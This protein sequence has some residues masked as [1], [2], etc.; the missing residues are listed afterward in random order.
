MSD[1]M[2]K[3]AVE[4]IDYVRRGGSSL[5]LRLFKPAGPGPH[6]IVVDIHG[7]AWNRGDLTEGRVRDEVLAAAGF[8]VAAVDFRQ[9]GDGYPTSLV[10]INYAIRWL[11]AHAAE[12]GGDANSV[13]LTGQSS[14]GHL[15][16]LSAMRPFDRRYAAE[17]LAGGDV[18][19]SVKC[20]AALWPVINPLSRY[21]HALRLRA[22][23]SPPAWVA[24]IPEQHD[25]YWGSE[26][27]MEE[28]NPMLILERGETVE[29]P[30]TLWVQGR[31]DEIHDYREPGQDLNEPQRFERNYR[32]A[33]GE[34]DILYVEQA[35][36]S[37]VA[38]FEAI[39]PFMR[40]HLASAAP[41]R[42][43][44]ARRASGM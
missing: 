14:G 31:P 19:A 15:A 34:L 25:I 27:A 8:I 24:D 1:E 3:F 12:I 10:D 4:D 20:V 35:E 43:A 21:R 39:V 22:G 6:P 44:P 18:D 23:G 42:S 30:P 36:R 28:G 16:M 40:R 17:P 26:G 37:S 2:Q 9:A 7:G 29:L 33:G 13:G 38:T 32:K 41:A 5:K 11:K